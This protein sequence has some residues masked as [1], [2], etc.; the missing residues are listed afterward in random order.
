[1]IIATPTT[2]APFDMFVFG[3]WSLYILSEDF[4]WG[5]S[6]PYLGGGCLRLGP[7][8]KM[9]GRRLLLGLGLLP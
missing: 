2:I 1:M 8:V 9:G 6:F 3:C 7:R 4:I 5:T